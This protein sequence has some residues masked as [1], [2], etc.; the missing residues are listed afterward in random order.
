MRTIST[1]AISSVAAGSCDPDPVVLQPGPVGAVSRF[2][3]WLATV[4]V[5]ELSD[6][7]RVDLVAEL[8]RVKGGASAAQAR[9]VHSVR[10]SREQVAPQDVAR[11]VGSEV[12]LARREP[13]SCGDRFVRVST[14]LVEQMPATLAALTAG[15]CSEAH[16]V[17][18]VEATS[19]LS[20]A[21]RSQVD[22]RVGP[23]LGRLG[24]KAADR[25]ARRVA[26]ELDAAAVVARMEAAVASR[27]VT[28]RAAADGMGY[29]TVLGPM[30]EVAGAHAALTARAR[31]VTAGHAP[32]EPHLGR[33][34][35]AVAADTAL[36]VLSGRRGRWAAA[37]GAS[38]GDDRPG[39]ARH[40]RP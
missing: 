20:S 35:G 40:R 31:T 7:E 28:V 30:T 11:S 13:P 37:R 25:A 22:A 2:R 26:A 17:R 27:R 10:R 5:G 12:A 38:P 8:E 19:C 24:V 15:V 39:V 1:W 29:L 16:A 6:R 36:R 34:V 18:V 4:D 3:E 9:L 32:E 14:A 21:D 33:G 23:L